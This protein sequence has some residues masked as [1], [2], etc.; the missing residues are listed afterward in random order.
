MRYVNSLLWRPET[1]VR[2]KS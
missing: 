2:R 1:S